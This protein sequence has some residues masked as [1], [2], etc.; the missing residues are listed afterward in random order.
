MV[1]FLPGYTFFCTHRPAAALALLL[2]RILKI[3]AGN[4]WLY[5]IFQH[6]LSN[7]FL[8][9]KFFPFVKPLRGGEQTLNLKSRSRRV[10]ARRAIQWNME[11]GFKHGKS[12]AFPR[13]PGF[14]KDVNFFTPFNKHLTFPRKAIL[15]F[16]PGSS[17]DL[18]ITAHP[19]L[20]GP[21]QT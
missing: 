12:P 4:I 11:F 13:K 9:L 6:S 10:P 19:R 8:T 15:D 20:P 17:P 1:L 2:Q 18:W 7:S 21:S 3:S 14:T 5:M 16:C